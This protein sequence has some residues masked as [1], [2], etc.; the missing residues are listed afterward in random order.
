MTETLVLKFG[1]AAVATPEHFSHVADIIQR[2]LRKHARVAVVVSAMRG[3]TDHLIALG[4]RVNRSPPQRESDMLV[5]VGERISGALLAMALAAKGAQA[6]SFTGSQAGI[7]TS[8]RHNDARIIAIRPHR[9]E[10]ALAAGN[11]TI[12]A[13]FQ[14]VSTAREITSLGRGGSDTTAVALALAL[15]AERV[16][17]YK[18]VAGVFDNDPKQ[19]PEASQYT[20][21]S[22]EQMG[23]LIANGAQVL[24]PRAVALAEINRLPMKIL[25]FYD[26]DHHGTTIACEEAR[27]SQPLFEE[28]AVS[29]GHEKNRV[30]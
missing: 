4:R 14:G 15:D 22:Y 24:H 13:G 26:L 16:E 7:I 21:L 29:E 5:T 6:V 28:S 18:D 3:M 19:C 25:P 9:V 17:F 30:L 8:S 2:H 1:G 20:V 10:A 27:R 12:V 11:V 23:V